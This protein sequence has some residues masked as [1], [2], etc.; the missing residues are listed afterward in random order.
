MIEILA[1]EGNKDSVSVPVL[2]T[3]AYLGD[4]GLISLLHASDVKYVPLL[5][6]RIMLT[7]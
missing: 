1:S 6:L 3:L 7:V 5:V 2:E 4:A